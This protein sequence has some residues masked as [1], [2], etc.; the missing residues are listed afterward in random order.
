V[1][2]VR[3]LVIDCETS[4]LPD[5][6]LP[7]DHPDQP[8]LAQLC[9]LVVD[10]RE[11]PEDD[12]FRT[13]A[14]GVRAETS[15]LIKPDGWAMDPD[16]TK[17]NG[18][19]DAM[20]RE[21]GVPVRDALEGYAA[22]LDRGVVV[23]A[24]NA[25]MDTKILRGEFRRAVMPDRFEASP[26]ICTM[27]ALTKVCGLRQKNGAPKWPSLPEALQHFGLLHEGRHDAIADAHG[28]FR[29]LAK[30]RE[31][32]IVPEPRVHYAKEGHPAR[33]GALNAPSAPPDDGDGHIYPSYE[34][35]P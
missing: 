8:R 9:M 35:L 17:V 24:H 22:E 14:F 7:A 34:V 23:V 6:K 3:F 13:E 10:E 31:L 27:R 33:T 4:S 12:E 29:L 21:Y 1:S 11:V 5:Y 30:M 32:G 16:A 25:R 28:C 2:D 19:T 20:L 26:T 18:L 15:F